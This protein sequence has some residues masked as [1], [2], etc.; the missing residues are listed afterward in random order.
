MFLFGV[1]LHNLTGLK[2]SI[3]MLSNLGHCINYDLVCEV[4][5]AK[6]KLALKCIKDGHGIQSLQPLNENASVLTFWWADNFNQT[7]ETQTG[8]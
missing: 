4:E 3:K 1:G 6:A 8:K 5:T 2:T 7:L